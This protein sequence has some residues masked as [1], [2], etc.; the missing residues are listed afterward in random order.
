MLNPAN[1]DSSES[2]SAGFDSDRIVR[3]EQ[4]MDSFREAAF[5]SE[6][7]ERFA[8]YARFPRGSCTWASFAFGVLLQELEP[9]QDWHLVNGLNPQSI[10]GHDWLE[11]G[12]LAVDCTADQFPDEMPFVGLSP[13]P[14]AKAWPTQRRIELSTAGSEPL[15]ALA[16]IRKMI[17]NPS[18]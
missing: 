16:A 10:F 1:H 2:A 13:P 17:Q 5:S 9:E 12:Y 4:L 8:G 18:G 7:R 6:I 15:A 3:I 14:V 11:D